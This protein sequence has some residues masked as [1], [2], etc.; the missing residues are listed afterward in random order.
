MSHQT[1]IAGDVFNMLNDIKLIRKI[2]KPSSETGLVISWICEIVGTV[3]IQ[4]TL[5]YYSFI[6]TLYD[7]HRLWLS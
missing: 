2:V 7:P 3:D 5:D 1:G 4:E 6:E